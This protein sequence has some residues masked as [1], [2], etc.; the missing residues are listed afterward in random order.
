MLWKFNKR[1]GIGNPF[2]LSELW[3]SIHPIKRRIWIKV[4]HKVIM[5]FQC[6]QL[7]NQQTQTQRQQRGCKATRINLEKSSC[8]TWPLLKIWLYSYF[9]WFLACWLRTWNSETK[10]LGC[11][12][13]S[14]LCWLCDSGQKWNN[15]SY[16]F[17]HL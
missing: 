2:I 14:N 12:I 1:I 10:C 13:G 6:P 16:M 8:Q 11:P 7:D 9:Q 3:K 17:L 5:F 15:L 4:V